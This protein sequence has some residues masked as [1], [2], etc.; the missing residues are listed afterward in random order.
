MPQSSRTFII[1]GSNAVYA[2][3]GPWPETLGE[4]NRCASDFISALD[5]WLRLTQEFSVEAVFD[6]FYRAIPSVNRE[7]LRII[8]SDEAKADSVILE[9]VRS[10]VYFKKKV[11][12]VTRD[13]DLADEA[14]REN[15][16]ILD[17]MKFWDMLS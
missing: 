7:R 9:R 8:F 12:V 4:Q 10:L 13:R 14:R 6:G 11:T 17:P 5:E 16:K 2:V 1:D 15:A 3:F